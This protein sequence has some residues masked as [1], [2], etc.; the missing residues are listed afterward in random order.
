[1]KEKIQKLIPA[2]AVVPLLTCLAVNF[3]VYAGI[4]PIADGWKHYDLTTAFDRA[5]PVVPEFVIIYLGCYL[6]GVLTIY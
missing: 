5:V 1:M 6:F 2:Y 3:L 4:A